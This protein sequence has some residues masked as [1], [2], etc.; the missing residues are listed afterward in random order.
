MIPRE[1]QGK[2][3]MVLWEKGLRMVDVARELGVKQVNVSRTLNG[4]QRPYGK[5]RDYFC[6]LL[7]MTPDELV[8]KS[9]DQA[10]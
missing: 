9:P 6:K 5:V 10:A 4:Y 8:G 3:R 7:N 1:I 2:I